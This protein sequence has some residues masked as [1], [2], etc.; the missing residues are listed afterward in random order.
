MIS[1]GDVGG[2]KTHV[3][4]LLAG[5]CKEDKICLLCF[6][7]G[8]FA[9]EARTLGIPTTVMG[10]KNLFKVAQA[11]YELICKDGY[12]LIHCHGARAN[13]MAMLLRRKL[14]VPM[15]S[16][17]HSDYRL[18]YIGRPFANLT[19]GNINRI[20][21]P[22][23]DAWVSVSDPM[24]KTLSIR[25]FDPQRIFTLY[26]G[27]DF[28]AEL[29]HVSRE[30][31]FR[32]IGLETEADSVV[33][34][35]AARIN[36]V[37]DMTTLVTAFAPV[38]KLHPSARLIIAGQG[39]EEEAIRALADKLCPKGSVC[40]A[41]WEK[42]INSFYHAIDV[43]LLTS[44]SEGF[45]Y[46]LPEGAR[47]RC[48]TISSMVGGVPSLIDHGING[49][50]FTPKD[51]DAL[52]EHMLYFIEHPKER[53]EM[54]LALYNKTK[55]KF[56]LSVMLQ[57]QREIYKRILERRK[58]NKTRDGVVICGAYGKGNKGDNTILSAMVDQLYHID[59]DLPIHV[60]SRN[61]SQ[62][63]GC[64]AVNSLYSFRL[65]KCG[66]LLKKSE[67][68]ISG[69]GTLMQDSTSTRSLLYY[70]Y[71]IRQAKKAGC[72]VMLYG[73]GIGP[74][75]REKNRK[76]TQKCL[77]R[78]ADLICV[79][80]RQS[81]NF[82]K[83]L[84][85]TK[86]TIHLTADP[87][88][89]ADAGDVNY[90]HSC[91]LDPKENYALF[92][93]RPWQ[94]YEEKDFI[95]IVE[96]VYNTHKLVPVLYCMEPKRDLAVLRSL[97]KSLHCPYLILDADSDGKQTLTLIKRMSLVVSMRL[98]TLIFAAGQGIPMVGIVYDP[99]V[100]GFLDDLGTKHYLPLSETSQ[101]RAEQCIDSALADCSY[102]QEQIQHLRTLAAENEHHAKQLLNGQWKMDNGQ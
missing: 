36:P 11:I 102:S 78:Y 42:D 23:F 82:L 77:D 30:E 50:L 24:T 43:N 14:S 67:L 31:Y 1:G 76:R 62:T 52:K 100:S 38:A 91:G 16:T 74:I 6:T 85:V 59:R 88:L 81:L 97:A 39:E 79:R 47:M 54:G 51:V 17:V 49:L 37:K 95:R 61:P 66:K 64:A 40:F 98:H 21:L 87:A 33:F 3:L 96:Y 12:E 65:W 13:L 5:L 90:L 18:D 15:V 84:G 44:I 19:F 68:Y 60:L 35:I 99:K 72:K 48:A 27:V 71:S 2:A 7:E 94:G 46:A 9:E 4:S 92:S 53:E 25:G 22:R 58:R 63:R 75:H 55:E 20:A 101:D 80:D 29:P 41:G 69:G 89:L 56:S 32:K 70:L 93:L 73:C 45:P 28:S 8:E 34:G 57:T 10:G 83:D 86:P 26:N